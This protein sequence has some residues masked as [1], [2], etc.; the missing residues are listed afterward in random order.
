MICPI[1]IVWGGFEIATANGE[2]AK[3][4]SG[5]SKLTYAAIGLVIIALSGAMV[6][7]IQK[8]LGVTP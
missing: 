6:T 7:V 1:Y 4:T 5:K 3:I 8:V 2:E